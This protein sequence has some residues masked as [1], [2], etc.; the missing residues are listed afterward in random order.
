MTEARA[1]YRVAR[2]RAAP[3]LDA[4][5]R[6]AKELREAQIALGRAEAEA[7]RA[8]LWRRRAAKDVVSLANLDVDRAA[9]RHAL[10]EATA[11]PYKRVVREAEEH[12]RAAERVATT[13]RVRQ[14]LE[15]LSWEEPSRTPTRSRDLGVGLEL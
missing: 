5:A 3:H 7:A 1:A 12:L 15:Q 4:E 10:A 11:A 13:E 9:E 2:E 8:P 14:R 6:A